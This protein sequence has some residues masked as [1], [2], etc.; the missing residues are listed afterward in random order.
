MQ[1][2]FGYVDFAGSGVV[3]AMGGVAGLAGALVLGARIG[4]YGAGRQAPHARGAQHPDGDARHVHPAVRL[5][6][7][8]RRV[9]VRGD[10]RPVRG[11]RGQHRASRLRSVP[12]W[13]CSTCMKRMGKPDPGMMANGML[14]GLVAITAPCAFVQPWAAA[15]IGIA[16]RRSSSSSRCSSSSAA[17]ST[18]RSARSRCTASCG[19]FGV[20]C[21]G[22]FSQ[23]RVRRR[24]EPHDQGRGG[25]RVR[26][27][28]D[29]VRLRP[30]RPPA[31]R[32]GDRCARHLHRDLRHRA[33]RSSRSRTR[34]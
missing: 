19:I 26:R 22:I 14:A 17:A 15:V 10:R 34:S 7:L 20:L 3:H 24:L 29:P 27:H 18:T 23:R 30:R 2:G 33:S 8:Q 31:R 11:G 21:V 9:D 1:L 16:R 6:R 13:R 28:R 4:K 32:A 25:D 5:V 12:R